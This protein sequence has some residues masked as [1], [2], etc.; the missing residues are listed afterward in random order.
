[1]AR[2]RIGIMTT[3]A[4]STVHPECVEAVQATG[5]LLESLGHAVDES[6]PAEMDSADYTPTR[7]A[8]SILRKPASATANIAA[9]RHEADRCE[10]HCGFRNSHRRSAPA[11]PQVQVLPL[12]EL[13][14]RTPSRVAEP[15]RLRPAQ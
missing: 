8:T 1:M 6:H 3:A 7:N 5:R 9:S 4:S 13:S 12:K 15:R 14:G 2:L 10:R 11:L